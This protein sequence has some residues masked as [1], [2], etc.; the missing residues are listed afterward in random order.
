MKNK[1]WTK[2]ELYHLNITKTVCD[3]ETGDLTDKEAIQKIYDLDV[4]HLK[5]E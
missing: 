3:W 1:E 4:E 2:D 5:N